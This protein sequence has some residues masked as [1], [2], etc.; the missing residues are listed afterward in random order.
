MLGH[1]PAA[2]ATILAWVEERIRIG[3]NT[4][5]DAQ[6]TEALNCVAAMEKGQKHHG[7]RT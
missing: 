7:R 5:E 2:P 3:K 4:R 1:D 6:I